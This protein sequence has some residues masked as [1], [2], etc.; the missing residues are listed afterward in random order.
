MVVHDLRSTLLP[1][2]CTGWPYSIVYCK[3]RRPWPDCGASPQEKSW[4]EPSD[5]GKASHVNCVCVCCFMRSVIFFHTWITIN[6]VINR[7]PS[8]QIRLQTP[9]Y[10]LDSSE[11]VSVLGQV[12]AQDNWT[13]KYWHTVVSEKGAHPPLWL[14]SKVLLLWWGWCFKRLQCCRL[15]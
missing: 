10:N 11:L 5:Q 8:M 3:W 15:P 9:G 14:T 2:T 6:K 1:L 13:V 7:V 12:C 4:C